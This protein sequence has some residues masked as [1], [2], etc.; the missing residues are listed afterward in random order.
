MRRARTHRIKSDSF[1][2]R[3]DSRFSKAIEYSRGEIIGAEAIGSSVGAEKIYRTTTTVSKGEAASG[4]RKN[5]GGKQV[6]RRVSR[7]SFEGTPE[8]DGG[9]ASPPKP[10]AR[11]LRLPVEKFNVLPPSTISALKSS[12]T[13][14]VIES[15]RLFTS[16]SSD[17]LDELVATLKEKRYPV[18]SNSTSRPFDLSY[19]HCS[20]EVALNFASFARVACESLRF[21]RPVRTWTSRAG[22][23]P[24]SVL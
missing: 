4:E 10:V 22:R 17:Q 7:S 21:P 14:K 5:S 1:W 8:S 19:P 11:L 2:E 13:Y 12:Y 9:N 23:R 3:T 16:F 18:R 6:S 20:P 15:T 24:H